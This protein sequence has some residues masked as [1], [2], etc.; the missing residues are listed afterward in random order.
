MPWAAVCCGM[1]PRYGLPP[2]RHLEVEARKEV[3]RRHRP[4]ALKKMKPACAALGKNGK[5][6]CPWG[7]APGTR[8]W[9]RPTG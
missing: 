4:Q 9:R 6:Q 3:F 8:I 7:I 1:L 5:D 2:A